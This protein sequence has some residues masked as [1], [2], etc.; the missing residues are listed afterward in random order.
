[1]NARMTMPPRAGLTFRGPVAC[2]AAFLFGA[3]FLAVPGPRSFG[4]AASVVVGAT[5]VEVTL[6]V[7]VVDAV[8]IEAG[9]DAAGGAG[10]GDAAL[11]VREA[12]LRRLTSAGP[13]C[14]R[15]T[16]A[17]AW[18]SRAG[19][20]SAQAAALW[21]IYWD[22][23]QEA[24]ALRASR[25]AP[26]GTSLEARGAA[27]TLGDAQARAWLRSAGIEVNADIRGGTSLEGIRL[28]T[29]FEVER[30]AADY[31]AGKRASDPAITLVVTGGTEAGHA[32]MR[33][34][35]GNGY[36]VDLRKSGALNAFIRRAY[37][38]LGARAD[39]F[40]QFQGPTG[41]VYA[42]EGTHWDVTVF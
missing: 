9:T 10:R 23:I 1:M 27:R 35:H 12:M 14:A 34:S 17:V 2:L 24:A 11:H 28:P 31:R 13:R 41:A 4:E 36:K 18:Y 29:L 20:S 30:L 42:D 5:R 39:G 37:P 21:T 40:P 26:G 25:G 7:G 19:L 8:D 16:D 38:S 15:L 6:P 3:L 32:V 22:R 33:V